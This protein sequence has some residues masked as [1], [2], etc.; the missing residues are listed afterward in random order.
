MIKTFFG[1]S[2]LSNNSITTNLSMTINYFLSILY[3]FY[4]F[5]I[6]HTYKN[7]LS[8][9]YRSQ[10]LIMINSINFYT[11]DRLL[12]YWLHLRSFRVFQ[13]SWINYLAWWT[14]T[15]RIFI[16]W[17]KVHQWCVLCYWEDILEIIFGGEWIKFKWTTEEVNL[18]QLSF[19]NW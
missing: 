10:I 7:E 4:W 15:K 5:S 18:L 17:I 16:K 14:V 1:F 3:I 8:K 9:L 11:N 2:I 13:N 19:K 6:V 12:E